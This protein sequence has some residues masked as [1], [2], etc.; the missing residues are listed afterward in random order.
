MASLLSPLDRSFSCLIPFHHYCC[1]QE[2]CYYYCPR[3]E[4]DLFSQ[5]CKCADASSYKEQ[6]VGCAL[7]SCCELKDTFAGIF[8][9][10]FTNGR[11]QAR[12]HQW[13]KLL[14]IAV[15]SP[16]S[17]RDNKY[18]YILQI[19]NYL[20]GQRESQ[21]EIRGPLTEHSPL[22][23]HA[24]GML[25]I[26]NRSYYYV[27]QQYRPLVYYYWPLLFSSVATSLFSQLL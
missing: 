24:F 26:S 19:S 8:F 6:S 22:S 13:S 18:E 20:D 7:A 12:S 27:V 9:E 23:M 5:P 16:S 25:Q 17:S 2:S 15:L 11:R 4:M 1:P 3:Y 14:C 21:D 10:S